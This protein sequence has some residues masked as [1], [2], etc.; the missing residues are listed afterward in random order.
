MAR[1]GIVSRRPIELLAV[2]VLLLDN[3]DAGA[4]LEFTPATPKHQLKLSDLSSEG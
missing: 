2:F 4:R 1:A 3:G